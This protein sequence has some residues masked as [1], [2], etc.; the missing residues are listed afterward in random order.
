MI[1]K[2]AI[3][4][5][6]LISGQNLLFSFPLSPKASQTHCLPSIPVCWR[7]SALPRSSKH[8]ACPQDHASYPPSSL[9]NPSS[10]WPGCCSVFA[11]PAFP[12]SGCFAVCIVL[13]HH[14]VWEHKGCRGG[15]EEEDNISS[16]IFVEKEGNE[17]LSSQTPSS[18]GQ[19]V[20]QG[21]G[22]MGVGK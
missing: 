6:L 20:L 11:F 3:R 2:R 5:S 10:A 21:Q 8:S 7:T 15:D 12:C 1:T 18:L 22:L 16:P 9:Q 4:N 14:M 19:G 17:A 13:H